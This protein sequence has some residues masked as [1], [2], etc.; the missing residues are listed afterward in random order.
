LIGTQAPL[1][2]ERKL[3]RRG[4]PGRHFVRARRV[5][6][7]IRMFFRV[8]VGDERKGRNL[9]GPVARDAIGV[10][11]RRDIFRKRHDAGL[12]RRR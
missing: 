7:G 12:S 8:V 1:T 11:N 9:S 2:D 4:Q 10:E 6:D 5:S 3:A